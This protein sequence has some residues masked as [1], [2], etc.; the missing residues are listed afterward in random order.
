MLHTC[1]PFSGVFIWGGLERWRRSQNGI[2]FGRKRACL[3][4]VWA[5][6]SVALVAVRRA[7]RL[8]SASV[9]PFRWGKAGTTLK[10]RYIFVPGTLSYTCADLDVEL[11]QGRYVRHNPSLVDGHS[12][13]LVIVQM[14]CVLRQIGLPCWSWGCRGVPLTGVDYVGVGARSGRV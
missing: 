8:P 14:R 1:R 13:S 9:G 3:A 2:C 12:A 10:A 6:K 5:G 4:S 7:L 11:D